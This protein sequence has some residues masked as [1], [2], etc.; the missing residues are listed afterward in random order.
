MNIIRR[1]KGRA[2]YLPGVDIDTDRIV[3]ARF[4]KEITFEHM[5]N[6]LFY[7]ERFDTE[8][9][10]KPHPLNEID[11]QGASIMLVGSGFGSGSSREH[12]PQAIKRAG[13]VAIIG[14][15]FAEIFYA[16]AIGL[17][18][19]CAEADHKIIEALSHYLSRH[20][21]EALELDVESQTVRL[22]GQNH[23]VFIRPATREALL[24]GRWD[25]LAELLGAAELLDAFDSRL[26]VPRKGGSHA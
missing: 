20:P 19:V 7:D 21:D 24:S 18:I 23:P 1:V 12:A 6:Y 8:G 17:G 14:E 5:G 9:K 25:P 2:V 11:Y 3:P 22:G 4:L 16:N 10:P 26:P 15:S 13:F